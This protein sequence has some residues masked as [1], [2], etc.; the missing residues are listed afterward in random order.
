[1]SSV[2]V[3]G[4]LGFI[5][6]ELVRQLAASG[7]AVTV[8][9]DGSRGS[10]RR[11]EGVK[12]LFQECDV[13]QP[14]E[15]PRLMPQT[16]FH[17]AAVNGTRNFYEQPWRVLEVQLR[18]TLNA[19]EACRRAGCKDFV[20]FSSSEAYQTPAKVPTPE[21]VP[22][23]VPDPANPRYSYGGGKLAAELLVRHCPWLDRAVVFRPHN[24]Y[25]PD[26]GYEHVI[27]EFAIRAVWLPEKEPD[28]SPP[29]FEIRGDGVR[30]F[31]H[32]EDAVAATV[33]AWAQLPQGRHTLNLGTE[34]MVT[35]GDLAKRVLLL[36]GRDPKLPVRW[37]QTAPPAG[38]TS[39]RCPDA[40]K[41]RQYWSKWRSLDEGLPGTVQWYLEHRSEWPT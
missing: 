23:V 14:F 1:M 30:A 32:V 33:S 38:G 21:E 18:G 28:W 5:G 6:A 8:L 26:M 9:D 10:M 15:L 20:L 7:H 31:C 40:R 19:L 39:K 25:G 41:I 22:L 37:R 35:M 3:S 11:L 27:P 12:H 16:F 17:L 13:T 24:V 34:E 29:T 2:V 36:S 4:G